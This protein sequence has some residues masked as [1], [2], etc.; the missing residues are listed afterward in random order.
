MKTI[1]HGNGTRT[2]APAVL[3]LSQRWLL[4]SWR[5]LSVL[6]SSKGSTEWN[7]MQSTATPGGG[8]EFISQYT[9]HQRCHD[10]TSD[11]SWLYTQSSRHP[12][13]RQ[14]MRSTGFTEKTDRA[15]LKPTRLPA[16]AH[17][18]AS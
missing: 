3:S 1:A 11:S 8:L 14:P 7:S 18:E 16:L 10:V 17:Q 9:S 5:A 2:S 15:A 12:A 13:A 6:L 4:L